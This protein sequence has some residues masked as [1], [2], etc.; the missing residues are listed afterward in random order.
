[1]GSATLHILCQA[2][3]YFLLLPSVNAP[4]KAFFRAGRSSGSRVS[5]SRSRV[6]CSMRAMM[7][8]RGAA[9]A[10]F[11]LHRGERRQAEGQGPAGQAHLGQG[12]A[13]HPA[14]AFH[15]LHLDPGPQDP[16]QV[17]GQRPGLP[18]ELRKRPGEQP[19]GGDGGDRLGFLQVEAQGGLQAGQGEFVRSQ[20]PGE[21]VPA[22]AGRSLPGSPGPG[23]PGV[24]LKSLSP[25]KSTR[26]AP[27]CKVSWTVGSRSK[28]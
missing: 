27:A 20:G 4:C 13:S 18:F 23:R 3:F 6:S 5:I 14:G 2:P 7:G 17:A 11:Q 1:M 19:Q 26:S 21:G 24:R 28:P 25:E 12:A 15:Y 16:Q 22:Q 9:Q 10:G 8:G